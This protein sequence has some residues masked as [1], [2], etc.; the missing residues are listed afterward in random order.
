MSKALR[1]VKNSS[2]AVLH[3]TLA[4]C[5]R[6]FLMCLAKTMQIGWICWRTVS[7]LCFKSLV[8][9]WSPST[10]ASQLGSSSWVSTCWRTSLGLLG[11]FAVALSGSSIEINEDFQNHHA[12]R[13]VPGGALGEAFRVFL[14]SFLDNRRFSSLDLRTNTEFCWLSD[15]CW[16]CA[17]STMEGRETPNGD[18]VSGPW[19]SVVSGSGLLLRR[20]SSFLGGA[21][22]MFFLKTVFELSAI[23]SVGVSDVSW[24][25]RTMCAALPVLTHFIH[26][27]NKSVG[28]SILER[29]WKCQTLHAVIPLFRIYRNCIRFFS[30][31]K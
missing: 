3:A 25:G 2:L 18:G 28:I 29:Y 16:C 1:Q 5:E 7:G 23:S 31:T 11:G 20:L 12:D 17:A 15:T 9:P 4:T 19:A 27:L 24:W 10:V 13:M 6:K 22:F 26:Q 8:S 14:L 30:L 21:E